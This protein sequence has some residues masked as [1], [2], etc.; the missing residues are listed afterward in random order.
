MKLCLLKQ[1]STSHILSAAAP[2]P[3]NLGQACDCHGDGGA[4]VTSWYHLCDWEY[5]VQLQVQTHG[6]RKVQCRH[7][8]KENEREEEERGCTL[9]RLEELGGAL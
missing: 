8:E 3:R 2:H 6:R 1:H 9:N 4:Q 5:V 7:M